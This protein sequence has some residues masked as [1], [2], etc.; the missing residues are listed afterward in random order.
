MIMNVGGGEL[1]GHPAWTEFMLC[2]FYITCLSLYLFQSTHLLLC[3]IQVN[4]VD[5]YI[6]QRRLTVLTFI[7]S[8]LFRHPYSV[9]ALELKTG[10]EPIYFYKHKSL[11]LACLLVP[12]HLYIKLS[13]LVFLSQGRTAF[14]LSL[15][16]LILNPL[17]EHTFYTCFCLLTGRWLYSTMGIPLS[18]QCTECS[19]QC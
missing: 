3:A 1:F 14:Q 6:F 8:T 12:L 5:I 11:N 18:V 15:G 13:C 9:G 16:Y 10:I 7:A 4:G 19:T 2:L 17:L